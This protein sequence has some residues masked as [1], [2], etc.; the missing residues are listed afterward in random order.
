MDGALA[1]G[2]VGDPAGDR[3]GYPDD[4]A[5]LGRPRNSA[6]WGTGQPPS[7]TRDGY[8]LMLHIRKM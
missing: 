8:L 7:P 5:D 2:L 3:S 6:E 1:G 4:V